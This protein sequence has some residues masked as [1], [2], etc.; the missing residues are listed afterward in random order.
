MSTPTCSWKSEGAPNQP[1]ERPPPP[2]ADAMTRA[3]ATAGLARQL[4][5]GR[6]QIDSVLRRRTASHRVRDALRRRGGRRPGGRR[7]RPRGIAAA[8]RFNLLLAVRLDQ[9]LGRAG[10]TGL[11][12]LLPRRR[13]LESAEQPCRPRAA[14]RS[15]SPLQGARGPQ[16]RG[17]EARSGR[18]RRHGG[19]RVET[20]FEL[21]CQDRLE[22]EGSSSPTGSTPSKTAR[23]S[24]V[25]SWPSHSAG[26]SI[27]SGVS[28]TRSPC[29]GWRSVRPGRRT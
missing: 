19:D 4:H 1:A 18:A 9:H 10:G 27:D 12:S 25:T 7:G 22:T 6:D 24:S 20:A 16:E 8:R 14:R 3:L 26:S 28:A 15:C 2:I 13:A 11:P 17:A 5:L 23:R 29:I 21:A